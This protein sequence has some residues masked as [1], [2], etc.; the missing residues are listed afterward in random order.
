MNQVGL[1]ETDVSGGVSADAPI[2]VER[3]MYRSLPG[4]PFALGTDSIGVPAPATSWFLAE[5]RLGRSSISM[6][7]SP[8]PATRTLTV[9]AQYAKPDG[10]LVTQTYVVRAHSRFSVYVDSIPG[11]EN[12]A[13]ATTLTSTN[14][15]PDRRR[16]GDVLA[17]GFFDYYEGHSSAGSTTTALEWVVGGGENDGPDSARTFVLIA[18][19]ASTPG[20]ATLTVL[21]DRGLHRRAAGAHRRGA[22]GQQP[23]D[24][25]DHGAGRHVRGAGGQH[26]GAPVPLVVESAVYRSGGGGY[27][28]R[29]PNALATPVVP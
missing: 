11:L 8:T 6:C 15:V 4:Q 2:V 20:E 16:A 10:T 25:A 13:V 21:P 14:A 24:G 18:N 1:D 23:D 17:G 9:T 27:G 12:T 3:A 29:A 7:S 26:R 5:A 19:T 22:A 28:R